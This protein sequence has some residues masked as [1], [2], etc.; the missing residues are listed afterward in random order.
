VVDNC[1]YVGTDMFI[2]FA[3]FS[4]Q[5]PTNATSSN[6]T[7]LG[8]IQEVM[9]QTGSKA[10]VTMNV[11]LPMSKSAFISRLSDFKVS[12]KSYKALPSHLYRG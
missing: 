10:Y 6:A 4:S 11:S 9:Q 5:V 7:I 1:R 2:N 3:R 12:L 8:D